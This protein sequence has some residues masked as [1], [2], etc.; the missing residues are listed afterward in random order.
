MDRIVVTARIAPVIARFAFPSWFTERRRRAASS[1]VSDDGVVPEAIGTAPPGACPVS[2]R[3]WTT[4]AIPLAVPAA[5]RR[6]LA[7]T[8]LRVWSSISPPESPSLPGNQVAAEAIYEPALM[9]LKR[10][11]TVFRDL[12]RSASELMTS[13]LGFS[14]ILPKTE[15]PKHT[16]RPRLWTTQATVDRVRNANLLPFVFRVPIPYHPLAAFQTL[17]RGVGRILAQNV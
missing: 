14:A 5:N 15:P 16:A 1:G 7:N 13:R 9:A 2:A 12:P 3:P 4:L 10:F 11:H 6:S 17:S 8:R